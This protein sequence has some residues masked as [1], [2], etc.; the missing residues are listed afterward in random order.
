MHS[1]NKVMIVDDN[2]IDIFIYK[3][4]ITRLALN[5]ETITF[6]N[7]ESSINYLQNIPSKT[8]FPELILID[9][10]M[11]EL[12][13]FD[14]IIKYNEMTHPGK[15]DKNIVLLSTFEDD[16]Q[17]EKVKKNK[18]I[19]GHYLKP[20]KIEDLKHICDSVNHKIS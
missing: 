6:N 12:N 4:L 2:E 8:P 16:P 3:K 1:L 5:N 9:I 20:L 17:I 7:V 10:N 15:R 19:L 14:F 13:G 11:P 18:N